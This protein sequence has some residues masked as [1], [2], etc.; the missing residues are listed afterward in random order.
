MRTVR[1]NEDHSK[2]RTYLVYGRIAITEYQ[3]P[4]RSEFMNVEDPRSLAELLALDIGLH[5]G[6]GSQASG[7]L[8]RS[9]KY[10]G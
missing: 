2:L 9:R 1:G 4:S 8:T 3:N 7:G 6:N 5:V 10:D